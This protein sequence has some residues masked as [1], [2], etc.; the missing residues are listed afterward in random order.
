MERLEEDGLRENTIIFL[1]SDHGMR[2]PRHKQ[3]IYEG[4]HKIPLIISWQGNTDIVTPGSVRSD[5][6]SGI[7]I[8]P[9]SLA[10]AGFGVPDHMEGQNLFGEH[11]VERDYVIAAK[12]RCDFTIDR[13]RTVRTQRYR[14]VRNFMTDRPFMQAQYR[15]GSDYMELMRTMNARGELTPEQ[16]FFWAEER[17]AEEFYDCDADPDEVNNLVD[18]PDHAEALQHHRDILT[19]WIAQTDDKGQ[20]PEPETGLRWVLKQWGDKCVNPEYDAIKKEI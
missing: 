9:T 17:V 14:Y 18:D 13:M 4:G 7:D 11:L 2:L 15:D 20:Y 10:L 1:F 19:Q 5:L 3:F 6:V 12:D 16:A 8:G